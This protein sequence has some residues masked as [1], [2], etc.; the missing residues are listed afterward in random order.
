MISADSGVVEAGLS[1]RCCPWP[2]HARSSMAPS[3]RA[4]STAR[5]LRTRRSARA[6]ARWS[7][8][9][10]HC[11]DRDLFLPDQPVGCI[12]GQVAHG[13]ERHPQ[14]A[15]DPRWRP[16]H[17]AAVGHRDLARRGFDQ[18]GE[19]D[20]DLRTPCGDFRST[21]LESNAARA[22]ATAAS[23]SRSSPQGTLAKAS[24]VPGSTTG[25]VLPPMASTSSPSMNIL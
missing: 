9:R 25:I 12:P 5:W 16:A 8:R 11:R 13:V 18:I 21:R 23:T 19:A 15:A 1:T 2:A 10:R 17:A 7:R 14:P 3:C 20:D 4:R 6:A 24:P 22:A